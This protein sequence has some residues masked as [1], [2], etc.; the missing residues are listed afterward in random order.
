MKKI[1]SL[2]MACAMLLS[3]CACSQYSDNETRSPVPR[4][5]V[6]VGYGFDSERL[7]TEGG[8]DYFY[9]DIATVEVSSKDERAAQRINASLAELFV[10]FRA[11]AEYTRKVAE[12]Q[13]EGSVVELR[14]AATAAAQ[15]CDVRVLSLTF[16]VSQD[17]GG[18]HADYTRLSRSY[19]ADSGELLTLDDIAR[20]DAQLRTYIK[21]YVVGIAAGAN[22]ADGETVATGA[23]MLFDDFETTIG[24]IVDEG[25][26]WYFNS[27]GLVVYANPYDIAPYSMG[28]MTFQIPYAALAEFIYDDF[29]PVA[30]EGENGMVLADDGDKIDRESIEL[31][32]AVTVDAEGQSVVL[33]A[34]ETVYDVRL[35]TAD[36]SL[37]QRNYLTTGEGVEVISFIPDG[38][39]SI[40][41]SYRLADGTEIVRGISQSGENTSIILIDPFSEAL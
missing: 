35:Y 34:E 11:D 31:V 23:D 22:Q 27:E 41:V 16:D 38:E 21:S 39:P 6:T 5:D 13:A 24:N 17:M 29:M 33:S 1:L 18:V 9:K 4:Y 28:V 25:S 7:T 10:K 19:N 37:W 12:D 36:K 32:G 40:M 26:N 30:Y 8:E 20:D 3:L 15:R 14:Y 2:L